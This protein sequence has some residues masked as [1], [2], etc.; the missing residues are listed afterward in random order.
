[1]TTGRQARAN[2]QF[3]PIQITL[4]LL[5]TRQRTMPYLLLHHRRFRIGHLVLLVRLFLQTLQ[6]H[7]RPRSDLHLSPR[8]NRQGLLQVANLQRD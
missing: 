3:R 2:C 6:E 5:R 7:L 8:T 1:M 4:T